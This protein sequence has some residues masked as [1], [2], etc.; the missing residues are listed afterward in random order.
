MMIFNL[1]RRIPE[2]YGDQP[3]TVNQNLRVTLMSPE[4]RQADALMV[5]ER[6][7]ALGPPTIDGEATETGRRRR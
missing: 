2:I 1:K 6:L 3:K 4:Q 5:L 7:A